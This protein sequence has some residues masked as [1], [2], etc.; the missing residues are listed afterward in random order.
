MRKAASCSQPLQESAVPRG[1]RMVRD[2]KD[3]REGLEF[4]LE[5]EFESYLYSMRDCCQEIV[6]RSGVLLNRRRHEHCPVL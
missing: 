3:L 6:M 4:E 2:M 1:A 5:F